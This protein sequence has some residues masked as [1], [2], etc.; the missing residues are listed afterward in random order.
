LR[1]ADP[2]WIGCDL[3]TIAKSSGGEKRRIRKLLS[4]VLQNDEVDFLMTLLAAGNIRALDAPKVAPTLLRRG[5]IELNHGGIRLSAETRL[6][7]ADHE[8]SQW[9]HP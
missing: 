3:P 7:L 2:A 9:V 5:W 1:A 4:R 8:A 6:L